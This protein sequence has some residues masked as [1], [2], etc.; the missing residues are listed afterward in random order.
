MNLEWKR[1]EGF[2]KKTKKLN[3]LISVDTRK[4]KIMD[5]A[6]KYKLDLVNDISGL[7]YDNSTIRF[8]KKNKKTVCNSS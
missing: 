7:N 2:F 5:L 6:N 1:I 3:C 8:F 4:S